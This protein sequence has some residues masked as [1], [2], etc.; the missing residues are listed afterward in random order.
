MNALSL[1]MVEQDRIPPGQ[2]P[3]RDLGDD[4][5]AE[6]ADDEV[7]MDEVGTDDASTQ[8]DLAD[9]DV[10]EDEAEED[11][12]EDDASDAPP[13]VPAAPP[14]AMMFMTPDQVT[15]MMKAMVQAVTPTK[16]IKANIAK[17]NMGKVVVIDDRTMVHLGG[18][19]KTDWSGLESVS[20]PHPNQYRGINK[21]KEKGY[22]MKGLV[23][24]EPKWSKDKPL[25][26]LQK[27]LM[28][29]L[30]EYGMEQCAYLPNRSRPGVPVEMI[31][32]I[33]SPHMF[34]RDM[35]H[36]RSAT[37]VLETKHDSWDQENDQAFRKLILS[38]VDDK[39]EAA[40][41]GRA[42]WDD[43]AQVTWIK[44]VREWQILTREKGQMLISQIRN[45][46]ISSFPG[47]N[48][49]TAV[50][51]LIARCEALYEIR[52]YNPIDLLEFI[53]TLHG[54]FDPGSPYHYQ[55]WAEIETKIR[56]P[57]EKA[58]NI[59]KMEHQI[60]PCEIEDV[61]KDHT[62]TGNINKNLDF[63]SILSMTKEMYQTQLNRNRWPAASNPKDKG[64][65]HPSFGAAAV[66]L[67]SDDQPMTRADIM[68]LMSNFNSVKPK[69]GGGGKAEKVCFGCGGKGHFKTDPECPKNKSHEDRTQ[70]TTN[71]RRF[72]PAKANWKYIGPKPGEPSTKSVDGKSFH[73]CGKCNDGKGRWTPSHNTAQHGQQT[74]AASG[75]LAEFDFSGLDMHPCAWY[76]PVA[77]SFWD[78][79][80][81]FGSAISD[82]SAEHF[83]VALCTSLFCLGAVHWEW[84]AQAFLGCFAWLQTGWPLMRAMALEFHGLAGVAPVVY[85]LV[86]L[87]G[88]Q[89]PLYL[90]DPPPPAPDPSVT[91]P[92][93]RE[94]RHKA[95]CLRHWKR[96]QSK[97][98]GASI[99]DYNIHKSYPLR[100]RSQNRY[101][102][103]HPTQRDQ[104]MLQGLRGGF[105]FSKQNKS[106]H[107]RTAQFRPAC[108]TASRPKGDGVP[109]R[110]R[111][112][113]VLLT[114]S[115]RR[116]FPTPSGR[117]PVNF[118]PQV[119]RTPS[120]YSVKCP[121][122][123][124]PVTPPKI[125]RDP[126][127]CQHSVP[128]CKQFYCKCNRSFRT[129]TQLIQHCEAKNHTPPF[130]CGAKTRHPTTKVEANHVHLEHRCVGPRGNKCK[131]PMDCPF[132]D[133]EVNTEPT[134]A[135]ML[136]SQE[137]LKQAIRHCPDTADTKKYDKFVAFMAG[138]DESFV[139]AT[140]MAPQKVRDAM[141]PESSF[142]LIWDS[143]ASVCISNN[144]A[145]FVNG[146][147]SPGLI[148]TLT[149]LAS[150]LK[151]KGV[152]EV[153]WTV[154]DVNG[155]PRTLVLP[156]FYVPN[157]PVRLLSTSSMLQKYGDES[158]HMDQQV[159][160]LSGLKGDS[161]RHAVQAFVNP[162]NNIPT[163][164]AFIL[165]EVQKAA[166]AL[167]AMTNTVAPSNINLSEPEKELLQWHQRLGHLDTR[168]I[169]FLLRSG[170]LCQSPSKRSLHMQ[171]SKIQPPKC[172]AC[173]FGKQTTR[174][175]KA[176]NPN[177]HASVQDRP[178]VLKAGQLLPGQRTSVDHFVCST[179]G[180]TL[181]SRGGANSNGYTGGCLFVD[182]A[183]GLVHVSFQEHLN[184]HETIV[185]K[186]EYETMA[187]DNGVVPT[188]Y[189]SDSGTAFT[190]QEFLQHL[191]EYRQ[192]IHFAGT[193]AHHHNAVAERSI[194][195]IMSIARTMMLHAAIHW[196][197]MADATLWPLAVAYAVHIFN[198]IPKP[199]SGL[200]PLDIFASSRQPQHKLQD[201][202]VWGSPTYLLDKR[203]ADG[204]KI[205]RW[206]AKSERVVFVGISTKH[207]SSTPQVLN[208][209]T[210]T[211]TTPYHVVFDD[212]FATVGSSPQELPNFQTLEWDRMFGDSEYQYVEDKSWAQPQP[213]VDQELQQAFDRR[214]RVAQAMHPM[215]PPMTDFDHPSPVPLGARQA[216]APVAPSPVQW[217]SHT[218]AN[219]VTQREKSVNQEAF[220]KNSFKTPQPRRQRLPEP[221]S[222]AVTAHP[223]PPTLPVQA[224]TPI[225]Q[226]PTLEPAP[227]MVTQPTNVPKE[228]LIAGKPPVVLEGRR[229][230]RATNLYSDDNWR[231]EGNTIHWGDSLYE[232]SPK[233]VADIYMAIGEDMPTDVYKA[234]RTDPDT[235]TLEQALA[236]TEFRDQWIACM[237]KEIQD[238]EAHGVW[239]E[240]PISDAKGDIIPTLW[241][242]KRKRKPDGS[243]DKFKGR[244]TVRGDLMK[245]YGFDT[246]AP[247]C[248][249]STIRM[250]LILSLTWGWTTC[251]CDYSNAFIHA[252]LETPVWIHLPRGYRSTLKGKTCLRLKRSLYG[253]SFAPM[254]FNK[255]VD[256][257]L[258]KYGLVAS[259]HDPCLYTKPGVMVCL[260]VDDLCMSFK[261]PKEKDVFLRKMREYGF[262]LTMD[263]TIGAF[264]G[265]QFETLKDG[266]IHMSQPALIEKVIKSSGMEGCCTRGTPAAPNQPLGKD[267][268]GAPMDEKWAY[269][270]IIGQLLY[271]SNNTR[272]D[273]T[274]AV[275]QVARFT[276]SPKQS[277]AEAVKRIVR[278]LAGT[279]KQGSI[280]KP[281]G[282]LALNCM[283]DSDFSGLWNYEPVD[284]ANS[285]RSRMGYIITLGGCMIAIKSKLIE[286]I[287]LATTEAEY[288]SLSHCLRALIPIRRLLEEIT[289]S[290]GISPE[291]RATISSTAFEDNNSALQLAT[292][293]RLTNRTRYYNT[294]AHHFW[295]H[296][297]GTV[298]IKR[299]DTDK[300]D[301]DYLTKPMPRP[302][303]ERNR[304]RVQ[305][306]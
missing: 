280:V 191:K 286:S 149:G 193:S 75:N 244:I 234:S 45:C 195:T 63:Q 202:H 264:L 22:H 90:Q 103:T 46:K 253:T 289:E 18:V 92:S 199:E 131:Y 30:V 207:L 123:T 50:D 10:P 283:S 238:L 219:A 60:G 167:H 294:Q 67:A 107:K 213:D 147:R 96:R 36:V 170:A 233:T 26:T 8:G 57:L 144:Q 295:Q 226:A 98:K 281:D 179:K 109:S 243:L 186:K 201:L 127:Q 17:P 273:I 154:L 176:K 288:Y 84:L 298:T 11:E 246:F 100:L 69:G 258:Q 184:T 293:H 239:E 197:D 6:V 302:G 15:D 129:E 24:L 277:H 231:V 91:P 94:R 183:S 112:R 101:Y 29:N 249:W 71:Q 2:E 141:R 241:I 305:G 188:E 290:V 159:A 27:H 76:T 271:L 78:V 118:P 33:L 105:H 104:V 82:F 55:W 211:I 61:F 37:A 42:D 232:I 236:D 181:T 87:A 251:T 284:D 161:N 172:A 54:C 1:P 230:R 220:P 175:V 165:T 143:G 73:W 267:P 77:T 278:Y 248:A 114:P 169:Q 132:L 162:S 126:L 304:Q 214:E 247:V 222:P 292:T 116:V 13:P 272:P 125:I 270:S 124:K 142:Q 65:P 14:E 279:P 21:S 138:A 25:L 301:A 80:R 269:N 35:D 265:I 52:E 38:S 163:C 173:Q 216:S 291:I 221:V 119:C 43:S 299:I 274:F 79:L 49:A 86:I 182:Q 178:P 134:A 53:Q 303:F 41:N 268:D 83:W 210:R 44:V 120:G 146:I 218:R 48:V 198:R 62:R 72:K 168:K 19:P 217:P 135:S 152:G 255:C 164:T 34:S 110:P 177:P 203:I 56:T 185:A 137:D 158:I 68:A 245:S 133:K 12:A 128:S 117:L 106:R 7:E 88:F 64:A 32:I 23:G 190:S 111:N 180:V 157:S 194:R 200:S 263:D 256:E 81:S 148:K 121:C 66:H 192:I 204:K 276:H 285:A 160:T 140:L 252:T 262:T 224:P 266:A 70:R 85:M 261:D 300:M 257:A 5:E 59:Y 189:I 74:A 297:P 97:L 145:D 174:P 16:K 166:V 306:W 156:C 31:N 58:Y 237:E 99:F 296:V 89:A 115:N 225:V 155:A 254:L 51:Y 206:Q 228:L 151:I 275:S 113:K 260:Y 28:T 212:W 229:S 122:P 287:C 205:P 150:G 136:P 259:K 47:M 3:I 209:R 9:D 39:I 108:R 242:C 240:V 95:K 223:T 93:R 171:A 196:P 4:L 20:R 130:C 250:V 153:A 227:V 102:S 235:L 40:V 139:Q 208:P 187:Q 282:T 215:P